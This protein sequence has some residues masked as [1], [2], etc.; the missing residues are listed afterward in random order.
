MNAPSISVSIITYNQQKYIGECLQSVLQQK[1]NF[2]FEVII[3][4]DKSTDGTSEICERIINNTNYSNVIVKYQRNPVNVGMMANWIDSIKKCQGKYIA[5]CEGDDYWTDLS[6]LQKQFNFLEANPKYV[7]CFHNTEERYEDEQDKASFL[8]CNYPSSKAISFADLSFGN[9]IPTC[10]V[11]YRNNL[12]NEFPDWYFRLNMA[13]WPLHLLNSQF[14]SFWFIPQ[15]MGVHRLHK[16]SVWMLQDVERNREF[17]KHA[18]DEM[19][20]GFGKGHKELADKL[21]R[22]KEKFINSKVASNN[23]GFKG[24]VKHLTIRTIRKL[25]LV[26]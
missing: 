19:I 25:G 24:R 1:C 7:G 10:S 2:E 17:I 6:K 13:D 23:I 4:D 22:G 9:L 16:E 18:Y 8:Y 20:S 11:M 26:K 21:I 5:L 12:F 15:V 14:G 3:N